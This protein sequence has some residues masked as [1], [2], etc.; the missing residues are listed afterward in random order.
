MAQQDDISAEAYRVLL[1]ETIRFVANIIGR[2]TVVA[3]MR[4][5]D[6]HMGDRAVELAQDAGL[7]HLFQDGG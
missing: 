6:E 3:Q 5:V 7:R 4:A 1:S 2:R